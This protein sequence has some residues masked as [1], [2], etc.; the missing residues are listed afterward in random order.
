[1]CYLRRAEN[2]CKRPFTKTVMHPDRAVKS[3]VEKLV[4]DRRAFRHWIHLHKE[5]RATCLF[6]LPE[7]NNLNEICALWGLR[8]YIEHILASEPSDDNSTLLMSALIPK[9]G[10][11]YLSGY[12]HL[13]KILLEAGTD[14]NVAPYGS[15]WR[16]VNLV[17]RR[18]PKHFEK[19]KYNPWTY[20]L[21]VLQ[22]ALWLR[23]TSRETLAICDVFL[24]RGASLNAIAA[25]SLADFHIGAEA[26]LGNFHFRKLVIWVAMSPLAMLKVF[27]NATRDSDAQ[28]VHNHLTLFLER[29]NAKTILK[30]RQVFCH[31][32]L[33]DESTPSVEPVWRLLNKGGCSSTRY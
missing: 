22:E 30:L 14:L 17:W 6:P 10:M 7:L 33:N 15:A 5:V 28:Q 9:E 16:S 24:R 31:F 29:N 32:S 21:G 1:M 18:K 12:A 8:Y 19:D 4:P 13:V 23:F 11:F 20:Y 2:T 27:Q 26:D 25:L 3:L